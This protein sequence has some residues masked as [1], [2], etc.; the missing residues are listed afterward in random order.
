MLS[1]VEGAMPKREAVAEKKKAA[2]TYGSEAA[3]EFFVGNDSQKPNVP[4]ELQK[5]LTLGWRMEQMERAR[6]NEED[7]DRPYL[8]DGF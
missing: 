4:Y 7:G 6:R 1:I 2:L 3:R 5:Q 8:P